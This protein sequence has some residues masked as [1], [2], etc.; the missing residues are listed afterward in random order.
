LTGSGLAVD[1][2]YHG[3]TVGRFRA[4]L[5][6]LAV[7]E[8]P[9]GF[10]QVEAANR[11]PHLIQE[12]VLNWAPHLARGRH[13]RVQELEA[14]VAAAEG[15]RVVARVG[16]ALEKAGAGQTA[17]E[18]IARYEGAQSRELARA[19]TLYVTLQAVGP[20]GDTAGYGAEGPD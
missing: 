16:P 3:W 11:D 18:F 7:R 17:L 13:Q 9:V 15:Q 1:R 12:A 6:H 5:T 8:W 14:A 4:A 20:A 2:R 19:L 10:G